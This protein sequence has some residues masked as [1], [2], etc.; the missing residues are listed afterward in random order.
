MRVLIANPQ[1]IAGADRASDLRADGHHV[2]V[3]DSARDLPLRVL[4]ERIHLVA[5][6]V[7]LLPGPP[8]LN[9][10]RTLRHESSAL[11]LLLGHADTVTECQERLERLVEKRLVALGG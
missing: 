3:S 5:L 4:D 2:V 1:H 11:L 10:A 6:D 9:L 7:D 8:L